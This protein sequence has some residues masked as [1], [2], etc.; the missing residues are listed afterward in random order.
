[1]SGLLYTDS[2]VRRVSVCSESVANKPTI[3]ACLFWILL[4]LKLC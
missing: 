2:Y 4:D 3:M 1:M